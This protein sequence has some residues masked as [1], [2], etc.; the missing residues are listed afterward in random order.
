MWINYFLGLPLSLIMGLIAWVYASSRRN[1]NI[2]DSLWPLMF[3]GMAAYFYFAECNVSFRSSL[4]LA[5][6]AFWAF[7]LSAHLFLRNHGEPEDKR[8]AEI[9][10]NN[11]PFLW[12]SLYIVFGLQSLLAWIISVPLFIALCTV[13][14]FGLSDAAALLLWLCGTLFETVSD[15][16]LY[17]F[18]KNPENQGKVLNT[19]LWRYSRHPNY[20]GEFLVW[21]AY[22][23]FAVGAGGWWTVYAPALMAFLLL[24]VSVVTLMEKTIVNRKPEYA[25]YMRNTNA[26]FPWFPKSESQVKK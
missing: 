24:R 26:F 9:R 16:K 10:K 6:V 21:W 20:F 7:R 1:V 5:L 18:K 2:V 3:L 22:F 4:I 25:E 12:K 17:T 11:P 14:E 8:Y 13:T 19:G 15:Y 23:L